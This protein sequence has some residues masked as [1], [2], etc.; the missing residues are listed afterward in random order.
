[1]RISI[2]LEV[3]FDSPL[4]L[5]PGKYLRDSSPLGEYQVLGMAVELRS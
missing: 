1:M 2:T 5:S 3:L 4:M